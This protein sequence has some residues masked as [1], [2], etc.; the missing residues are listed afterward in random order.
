MDNSR[1]NYDLLIEKL[2]RFIRKYYINQMIRGF[3][4]AAA[5]IL[6]CFLSFSVLEHFFY[7]D[8][9]VRKLF[10]FSFIGIS[11]FASFFWIC[12]PVL[13]YFKLG[14][15][16]SHEQAA[17]IIGEHFSGIKDKLLNVLQLKKQNT[18]SSSAE[19]IEASINQKTEEIKLVPFRAA[20]DLGKNR[21][22]LKYAL[23][24]FLILVFLL[25]AAP[26]II[27]DSTHRI[28]NNDTKF[29]KAAP[30]H[31]NL[32][33]DKLKVVQYDDYIL[34][35]NTQGS[36]IP[37][38]VFIDVDN[39]Q[40]RL[41]KINNNEF[42]YVFKNVQKDTPFKLFSGI[43]NSE[44]FMLDVLEKP[45]IL[46][47]NLSLDYPGYTGRSDER[48]ENIGDIVAPEGTKVNWTF[49]ADHTDSLF[50]KFGNSKAPKTAKK[51]SANAFDFSRK[52]RKDELYQVFVTNQA[53][54][55]G[56][57]IIY[58]I[59]VV[60]DQ[61]PSISVE[62]FQD[63]LEVGLMYF[64]GKASDDYGLRSLSFNYTISHE[65]GSN[66]PLKSLK[67]QDPKANSISFDHTLDVK[68]LNLQPGDNLTFYFE[69]FDNDGVNGSKSARTNPMVFEKPSIDE[70]KK[71]EDLNEEQIKDDLKESL[72][73]L[74]KIREEFKKL[75][76]KLLQEKE[77]D[78]QNKKEL[79]KLLEEQKE[80]QKKLEKAKEKFEEN[81]KKQEEIQ[82]PKEEILEKQEKLQEMFEEVLNPE[83]QELMEKI[84]EMLEEL[85]KD[86]ALE[87]MEEMEMDDK[88]MEKEM[89]RLMELFKQL[90]MEKEIKEQIEKLEE[91]A[92]KQEELSEETKKE[93]KP[94]EELKKEQEKINEEFEDIK[95]KIEEL[96]EKNEEL[97]PPKDLG[98]DNEEQMEDIQE[99]LDDSKESLEKEENSK[100]SDSQKK[101]SEKMKSMAG[102]LQSS[103]EAGEMEQMEEDMQALRQ[104]LENLVDLSFDQ[105]DL[106]DNLDKTKNINTPYYVDLVQEQFKLKDDFKLISDSLFTLSK[107]VEQIETFV[108]EKVFEVEESLGESLELLEER[109]KPRASEEQRV[110]IKNVNDLA[111]MLSESMNQMQQQMSGMMP[112]SQMCKK[113]GGQG[114]GKSGKVPSDKI[115]EGQGEL[116]KGL[117]KMMEEMK[118]GGKDGKGGKNGEGGMSKEFAKAAARQA[119]LRKALEEL[120]QEQKE[121]GNGSQEM[122]KLIDQMDKTEIDLVNKRL[123]NETLNRQQDILTRLLKAEKADRQREYEN[124][125][126]AERTTEKK[127]E[128]PPSLQEYLK[129]REAEV[130]IYK[131]IS[132]DLRPYYKVLVDK[133]YQSLKEGK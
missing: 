82:K 9:G 95:E 3:L 8:T 38:E 88:E 11:A 104:L 106:Y 36:A 92:E 67:L 86:E 39:F 45:N 52:L 59:N 32:I 84:Q 60:P 121:Q 131:A 2:D 10:F 111:L 91:L 44:D 77:L 65:D 50:V 20:I 29:E 58:S 129:K 47:F 78:W 72:K 25:F 26:S 120:H 87:M 51:S 128:F 14:Q 89:D 41:E 81:I 23:P 101:A 68:D 53:V 127:R 79:E 118:K 85:N 73:D 75:R 107:R 7:F 100:A 42:Q 125:R 15:S 109:Q 133:Y 37:N 94:Q 123:N 83:T 96:E 34:T 66:D 30:F 18:S 57:S 105:E 102:N 93:E 33:S 74:K 112:G 31:F 80:M 28:I 1:G 63:S 130:E 5:L 22:Y 98:D 99:E 54:P 117:K 17:S 116:N 13:N 21:Q 90:E 12:I 132:P 24:P 49:K 48:I 108:T 110:T 16:I 19:L 61:H 97:T 35:I 122:Q 69:T 62:K 6:V 40:Y 124:K 113:P 114:P 55:L 64:I 71:E 46:D 126:K 27:K 103:M 115:S 119:A 56:D 70:L 76:E 43:V 4:Y